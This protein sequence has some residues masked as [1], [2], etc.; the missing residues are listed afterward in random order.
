MTLYVTK[1]KMYYIKGPDQRDKSF[2]F[3]SFADGH[4]I[5]AEN[6]EVSPKSPFIKKETSE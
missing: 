1:Y 5:A 3:R 4:A 2:F 6:D